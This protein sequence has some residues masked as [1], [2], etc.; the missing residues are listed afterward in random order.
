MSNHL[1]T[2]DFSSF[3]HFL[4]IAFLEAALRIWNKYMS[5][6]ETFSDGTTPKY[7]DSNFLQ[8]VVDLL[9]ER[10]QCWTRPKY[11]RMICLEA[12]TLSPT[13][14]WTGIAFFLSWSDKK[15]TPYLILGRCPCQMYLEMSLSH[16]W[17]CW[18]DISS[19]RDW[20][21]LCVSE[22]FNLYPEKDP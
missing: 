10:Q 12:S 16:S 11:V 6:E 15:S 2:V 5:L 22:T 19:G 20:K 8:N 3:S 13:Y 17:N 7:S 18:L 9:P 4:V 21:R 1:S 14:R